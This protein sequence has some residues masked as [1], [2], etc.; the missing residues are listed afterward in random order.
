MP[1]DKDPYLPSID[2]HPIHGPIA[3]DLEDLRSMGAHT[4]ADE[5]AREAADILMSAGHEAVTAQMARKAVDTALRNQITRQVAR[6]R[7]AEEAGE[8]LDVF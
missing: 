1:I 4:C 5:A 6:H 8:T 3:R 7:A 2:D